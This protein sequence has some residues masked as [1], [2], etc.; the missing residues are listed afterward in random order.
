MNLCLLLLAI[1][2]IRKKSGNFLEEIPYT[3]SGESDRLAPGGL[4]HPGRKS[5]KKLIP[6]ALATGA[7]MRDP[8]RP[9]RGSQADKDFL[10]SAMFDNRQILHMRNLHR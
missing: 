1:R 10:S 3:F 5:S 2:F 8:H 4:E 7:V 6:D 9:V